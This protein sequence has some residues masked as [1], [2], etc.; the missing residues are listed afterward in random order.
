MS[1]LSEDV[2][3]LMGA[4]RSA[5]D[6]TAEDQAR[7]RQA[8]EIRLAEGAGSGQPTV[9]GAKLPR[10][11]LTTSPRLWMAVGVSIVGIGLAWSV[12]HRGSVSESTNA[13]GPA[14]AATDSAEPQAVPMAPLATTASPVQPV[15]AY[16]S[17][18]TEAATPAP[19]GKRRI[20]ARTGSDTLSAEVA[21][22]A[23]ATLDLNRDQPAAALAAFDEHQRRFPTGALAEERMAGRVE[24]LCAVGRTE[25]AKLE[26]SRLVAGYPRSPH[27]KHVLLAC[28][29]E[30]V[31]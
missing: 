3:A 21:L 6:P 26:V 2:S 25:D 24:A 31:P 16:S 11:S 29:W 18:V 17:H 5:L 9:H 15:P 8:L 1:K 20:T 12:T 22:L 27:L 28:G 10:P 19:A 7:V 23:E 14:A 13:R 30:A 4:G